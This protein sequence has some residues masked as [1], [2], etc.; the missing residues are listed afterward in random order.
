MLSFT[1]LL[2]PALLGGV[3]VFITSFVLRMVLK[4]HWKDF[5]K[6]PNEGA[7][8]D[9]LREQGAAQGQYMFP[10]CANMAEM[11]NTDGLA[12]YGVEPDTL[13]D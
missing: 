3:A 7:V 10:H 13:G 1:S 11:E 2:L 12:R 5:D 8:M 6:L 9:A 4:Y